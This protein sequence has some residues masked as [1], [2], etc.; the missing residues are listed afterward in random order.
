LGTLGGASLTS[1][2]SLRNVGNEA[3][4]L[5]KNVM[6]AGSSVSAGGVAIAAGAALGA[7]ALLKMTKAGVDAYVHLGSE[8]RQYQ[9]VTG[10]SAEESSRMVAASRVLGVETTSLATNMLR[11]SK[12]VTQNREVLNHHGIEVAHNKAGQV[13]LNGTLLKVADA[14]EHATSQTEKNDIA[15]AAFSLRGRAMLPILARGREGI[16]E[17]WRAAENHGEILSQDD[18]DKVRD[19]K[20]AVAELHEAWSS[21]FIQL[22]RVAVP[23]LTDVNRTLEHLIV[24]GHQATGV[25]GGIVD[26]IPHLPEW[27]GIGIDDVA[28][29][30]ATGGLWGAKKALDAVTG[31]HDSASK[32]AAEQKVAEEDLAEAERAATE[33]IKAH[34]KAIDDYLGLTTDA[35]K[36][37]NEWRDG[38]D[39]LATALRESQGEAGKNA[40]SVDQMTAAGRASEDAL[41][42]QVDSAA[43]W[44]KS[45]AEQGAS[46]DV[47]EA[48]LQRMAQELLNTAGKY[49]L[50]QAEAQHYVDIILGIPRDASTTINLDAS[51]AMN[52]IDALRINL[53]HLGSIQ[54]SNGLVIGKAIEIGAAAA[55]PPKP[56]L[57]TGTDDGG[58]AKRARDKAAS[59]A[60]QAAEE[61]K[62]QAED[63]ARLME[64]ID[65]QRTEQMANMYKLGLASRD[66]YGARTQELMDREV[67]AGREYGDEWMRLN[68][69][70]RG[71]DQDVADFLGGLYVHQQAL[72]D[73]QHEALAV[74]NEEYLAVLQERLG[75]VEEF[76]DE[77]MQVWRRINQ[78]ETDAANRSRKAA[79]DAAA[80]AQKTTEAAQQTAEAA[81]S[82]LTGLLDEEQRIRQQMQQAAKQHAARMGDIERQFV[83]DQAGVFDARRSQLQGWADVTQ[84]FQAGWGNAAFALTR[85][86]REQ[87]DAFAEWAATLDEA[88]RRGLSSGVIDLLG[89]DQG[90]Q[91]LG[92]LR[93]FA[94]ATDAEIADLN[95]AVAARQEQIDRRVSEE[96]TR[97]Y[98]KITAQLRALAEKH[99]AEVEA[100]AEE[101]LAQQ[102]DLNR[103]LEQVGFDGGRSFGAAIAQGLMSSVSAI[104]EAA[105]AAARA[106]EE[107]T[108]AGQRRDQTLSGSAMIR[109]ADGTVH[110]IQELYEF[111]GGPGAGVGPSGGYPLP[112]GAEVIS[113]ADGTSHVPADGLYRLH[114]GE[115]V[116]AS[117]ENQQLTALLQAH[118]MPASSSTSVQVRVFVGDR[119][120]TDI[121]RTEVSDQRSTAVTAAAM[122]GRR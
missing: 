64:A 70:L 33:A 91:A 13:D 52:A 26:K 119:E 80:A 79:D 121:V 36:F 61:A 98:S 89:L 117:P 109:A 95:A 19:Y 111:F 23:L 82:R 83:A 107:A 68:D 92:Q 77:W 114:Q 118:L 90:P 104:R 99:A 51:Q 38:L 24:L 37:T 62:R 53:G 113:Y 54:L 48:G 29:S 78:I 50:P 58:A 47:I 40:A 106:Q 63:L 2:K 49:R 94:S 102:A 6:S 116:V 60:K 71:I 74:S 88:Q 73:N 39:G 28:L 108:R 72:I 16:E 75:L 22:G 43:K 44:V 45:M 34:T 69:Q 18:L 46:Q 101:F 21:A 35:D 86:I 115:R 65:K 1:V 31:G 10:A 42:A 7:A 11:L 85:N 100:A 8:V 81:V 32:A 3:L 59:D 56:P 96:A 5:G 55:A 41:L 25:I 93:M 110:N 97:S 67:A 27:H 57:Y 87:T 9:R 76:S 84:R 105:V 20:I 30:M 112:V 66:D 14:Y 17:L 4:N 103:Q 12:Q 122:A 15:L 120:I